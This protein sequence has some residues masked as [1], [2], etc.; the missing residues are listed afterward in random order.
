LR[1]VS[2][3][4]SGLGDWKHSPP[5]PNPGYLPSLSVIYGDTGVPATGSPCTY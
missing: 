1:R 5:N 3:R 2:L 4:K